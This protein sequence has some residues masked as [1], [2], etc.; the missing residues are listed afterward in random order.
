MRKKREIRKVKGQRNC[1]AIRNSVKE[2]VSLL[3]KNKSYCPSENDSITAC[4][5]KPLQLIT[6]GKLVYRA[7][8]F[9]TILV[10]LTSSPPASDQS[11]LF[12]HRKVLVRTRSSLHDRVIQ[13]PQDFYT[14]SPVAEIR[15]IWFSRPFYL[16]SILPH[17]NQ[18]LWLFFFYVSFRLVNSTRKDRTTCP[19]LQRDM[20]PSTLT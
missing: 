10:S 2:T 5:G 8:Q 16:F 15:S 19:L 1:Q 12:I 7:E 4:Q 9:G 11:S 20:P 13:L 14:V 18:K 3:L 6:C 17:K